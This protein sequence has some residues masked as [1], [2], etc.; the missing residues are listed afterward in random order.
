M[1][2]VLSFEAVSI[3]HGRREVLQDVSF[4]V[5][6]GSVYA[7]LGRNGAGKSSLVRCALG[8]SIPTSGR[9]RLFDADPW[10]TRRKAMARIGVVPEEPDAPPEMTARALGRFCGPL[11]PRWDDAGYVERITRLGAPMDV[12]FG[13]LSK[14]QKGIVMLALALAPS[15]ELLVLDDPTLGLDVVAKSAVFGEL[16]GDLADRGTT[17]FV[18]SHELTAIEALADRIGILSGRRLVVDEAVE[19]LKAARSG[20]L[21]D[22][23]TEVTSERATA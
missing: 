11:Y 13:K 10:A 14:G 5:A 9:V 17:V 12:A 4:S 18:T 15:P 22:I 21:E 3:R 6:P 1:S 23:F 16:I 7:L 20:S 8:L 19:S 2:G